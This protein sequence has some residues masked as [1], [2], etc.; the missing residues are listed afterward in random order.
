MAFF[1]LLAR[2]FASG[3][4][5]PV[6]QADPAAENHRKVALRCLG[7]NTWNRSRLVFMSNGG[8][9]CLGCARQIARTYGYTVAGKRWTDVTSLD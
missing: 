3:E 1:S 4:E 8:D 5:A 7:C 9:Y 6:V 2:V